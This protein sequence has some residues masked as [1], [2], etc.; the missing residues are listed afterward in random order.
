[1]KRVTWRIDLDEDTAEAA[2]V[3][4]LAIQ[5]DPES[6]ATVFDVMINR[7]EVRA[8]IYP[9]RNFYRGQRYALQ[10]NPMVLGGIDVEVLMSNFTVEQAL[11][12]QMQSYQPQFQATRD[13]YI[14]EFMRPDG[15]SD[16]YHLRQ[17]DLLVDLYEKLYNGQAYSTIKFWGYTPVNGRCLMPN[18]F[19]VTLP[20]NN[21]QFWAQV[22]DVK[23]NE[24]PPA[25]AYEVPVPTGFNHMALAAY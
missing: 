14:I 8:V 12:K 25:Q 11:V 9:E 18:Q 19:T 1:M 4:A 24:D 3:V 23:L 15:G 22:T 17:A 2:A 21:T 7:D 13:H 5:R 6:T 16:R 20:R 10:T